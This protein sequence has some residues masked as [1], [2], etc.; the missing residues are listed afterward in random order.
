VKCV[1][2]SLKIGD[3]MVK[4]VITIEADYTIKHAARIMSRFGIGCLVVIENE[5]VVGMI[6][7]R[8]I[9][10]KIVAV[11]RDPEKTFVRDVASKP[12]IVVGTDVVL[13]DAIRLMFKHEIKKLP[14]VERYRGEERL[15]GLVTLTD[16]ARLQPELIEMLKKHFE[17][18]GKSPPRGMEKVMHYY[19]V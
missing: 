17:E 12:V 2:K 9:L 10:K 14:V 15:A 3:V 18:A 7:E 19:I 4:N 11:A 16:I 8:D 6:T 1:L 13:D 5:K